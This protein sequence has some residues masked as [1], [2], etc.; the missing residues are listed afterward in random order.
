MKIL[1]IAATPFFSDRG[2]HVRIYNEAKYLRKF[3]AEVKIC[4]YHF[5][6]NVSGLDVK[7]ISGAKWYKKTAPGFS[8]GKM[9][10]DLKLIF[11]C[12]KEIKNFRPDIIHAHLYEGLGIAYWAKKLAFQKEIPIVFDLQG[13]LEEEFKNYNKKNLIARKI[14]T[15]LSKKAINWC[16]FL[17]LS[18]PNAVLSIKK[19]YKNKDRLNVVEDG[20][21]LD[22]FQNP[23]EISAEDKTKIEKLKSWAQNKKALV[24]VGGLSDGKGTG[25][26]L[27]VFSKIARAGTDWKLILAGFGEGEEKYRE[28]VKENNLQEFV[29]LPG[30]IGYFSGPHLFSF[31][32]AAID[33][34]SGSAEGSV[35]LM[36][37]MA[38]GLPVVCFENEFNRNKLGE[39]GYFMREM[40]DLQNILPKIEKGKKIEYEKLAELSEEKETRKL[41]EIFQSII[42]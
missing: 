24:Y 38:A 27:E 2:C 19:I 31:A 10:L 28:Y 9:W 41:F 21:D 42:K 26:L 36:S 25:K 12:R 13:D 14:F 16:D 15:W 34:K 5:G 29:N 17:V 33:P 6:R 20:T 40:E 23:P 35:K 37:Y 18:S 11:L 22:L 4:T 1:T 8:W 32:D 30:R 3:G 39:A 7:R